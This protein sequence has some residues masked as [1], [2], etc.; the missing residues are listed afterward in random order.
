VAVASL[1]CQ[2]AHR[3]PIS[4]LVGPLDWRWPL[5][6]LL[7]CVAGALLMLLPALLLWSIGCVSWRWNDAAGLFPSIGPVAGVPLTEELIF[8]GFMFQRLI[9]GL[10][11]LFAQLVCGAYFVLIHAP[12][13]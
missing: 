12:A 3:H 7:G 9:D 13:P 5:Q 4:E 11:V 2:L 8:R 6:L 1:I 10:G